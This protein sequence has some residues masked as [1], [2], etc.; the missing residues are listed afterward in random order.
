[1]EE[2]NWTDNGGPMSSS[3][4]SSNRTPLLQDEDDT[5]AIETAPAAVRKRPIGSAL[6]QSSLIFVAGFLVAFGIFA[7]EKGISIQ[8][9]LGLGLSGSNTTTISS[10]IS[11]DSS[12]VGS[13][14]A[15]SAQNA[16]PSPSQ[17]MMMKKKK[18]R[19]GP[20]IFGVGLSKT[21]T[22][23][24]SAAMNM[25]GYHSLH[26]DPTLVHFMHHDRQELLTP[27]LDSSFNLT[28]KYDDVDSV[29][30]IPTAAYYRQLHEAYP[31]AKFILT[32]RSSPQVWYDS[33]RTYLNDYQYYQWGCA[34]PERIQRLH[35]FVYGS[36]N[37]DEVWMESYERHNAEVVEYFE[38]HC[39]TSNQLLIMDLTQEDDPWSELCN[40]LEREDGPCAQLSHFDG[41]GGEREIAFPRTNSAKDHEGLD[42]TCPG[43]VFSEELGYPAINSDL[44]DEEKM[45]LEVEQPNFA[46]VTLLCDPALPDQTEYIRMLLV[47]LANIRSYDAKSDV[48]VMVHGSIQQEQWDLLVT[49]GLKLVRIP[50]VGSVTTPMFPHQPDE[51]T[52]TCYRSKFRALQL[53][54]YDKILFLDSDILLRQDVTSMFHLPDF[55]IAD[56]SEAP[57]NAGFFL[58]EPSQQAFADIYD[59][60]RTD[61]Y[62]PERGWMD[63][64]P[65]PH[66]R[67]EG[68]V[69]DWTFWCATT[70]QGLLFYYYDRLMN[71]AHIEKGTDMSGI[72]THFVG[73]NKPFL[74]SPEKIEDVPKRYK[75]AVVAW[76]E[77]WDQVKI[78]M[79]STP[80]GSQALSAGLGSSESVERSRKRIKRALRMDN[81]F[82]KS[83]QRALPPGGKGYYDPYHD[84]YH[85]P[86]DDPYGG[87]GGGGVYDDDYFYWDPCYFDPY[88]FEAEGLTRRQQA[89]RLR[90]REYQLE[91]FET[92]GWPK[93]CVKGYYL[94]GGVET[95]TGLTAKQKANRERQEQRRQYCL[96]YYQYYGVYPAGYNCDGG[97]KYTGY[98]TE[99]EAYYAAQQQAY[100]DAQQQAYYD[101]YYAQY[102]SQYGYSAYQYPT[103]SRTGTRKKT[104]RHRRK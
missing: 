58:A 67:Q 15:S 91:Y 84:P 2:D 28:G 32:V 89:N 56:G 29:W 53:I 23:S 64:G 86:Y 18:M 82:D 49:A 90:Q 14:T 10:Q 4:L 35:E 3:S 34:I 9:R 43:E 27:S 104:R 97:G 37:V 54:A 75:G 25:L 51:R 40:F 87:K 83:E 52:A 46:Y 68:N 93:H 24:L 1:M 20:K 100:Y 45:A 102:G 39:T 6:M 17:H 80:Q 50:I 57:M 71:L 13:N 38:R 55:V 76:Y 78:K 48:V 31:D 11:A 7:A 77:L 36:R 5:N 70:D 72:F 92:Y 79:E 66:W 60:W 21:G 62:T 73:Q 8:S 94:Q 30:D 47:L 69:T 99:Q 98:T 12:S 33:F 22:T 26:N 65:F 63:Y 95:S 96:Q 101:V 16:Q 44:S 103:T 74:Y 59:I 85:D 81:I 41:D 19:G 61:S 42:T 88:Y